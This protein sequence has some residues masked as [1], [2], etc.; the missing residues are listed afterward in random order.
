MKTHYL[1]LAALLFTAAGCSDSDGGGNSCV[2]VWDISHRDYMLLHGNVSHVAE[3]FSEEGEEPF[4]LSEA[5]FDAA[6][7]LTW[8]NTTGMDYSI[9]T[10]AS[11]TRSAWISPEAAAYEYDLAGRMSRVEIHALGEEEPTVY[12]I[13]Y[14][15]HGLYVPVP[16][17]FAD[18]PLWLLRGV[19]RITGSDGYSLECDGKTAASESPETWEGKKRTTI[20]FDGDYP[21]HEVTTTAQDDEVLFTTTIDYEW[22]SFGRLLRSSEKM[23]DAASGDSQATVVDYDHTLLLSPMRTTVSVNGET[24]YVFVC[25]YFGNGLPGTGDYTQ[26]RG[27]SEMPF[28]KNY[29]EEDAAGN[30][31]RCATTSDGMTNTTT[32]TI[33]YF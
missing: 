8:Y 7:R 12:E 19:T 21:A 18:K 23:A 24:S 9:G 28:E 20:A 11:S 29:S 4:M 14:G 27:F 32:R 16:F 2:S 30:W 13:A 17:H 1:F 33:T 3:F 31:T 15:A 25:T 10:E 26:G 5:K 6:G 22:D